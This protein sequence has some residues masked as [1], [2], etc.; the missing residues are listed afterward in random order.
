MNLQKL[1]WMLLLLFISF[2]P[3]WS[4]ES[5]IEIWNGS[6]SVVESGELNYQPFGMESSS[7]GEEPVLY[8][9]GGDP[10]GG[11]PVGES[12]WMLF[13]LGAGVALTRF[14]KN[15]QNQKK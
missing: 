6:V 1:F 7:I 14:V 2:S 15:V 12:V 3:I 13:I 8:G 11:L 4:I 10:I 9:P 5:D